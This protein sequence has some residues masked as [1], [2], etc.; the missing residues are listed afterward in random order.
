MR[1]AL[2][3]LLALAAAP[4]FAAPAVP[5]TATPKGHYHELDK[6]PDWGG[7]WVLQP[8]P[9][10]APPEAK[11]EYLAKF[12]AMKKAAAANNGEFPRTASYCSPLGITYLMSLGQYPMEYLFTPGRVTILLEAY[13]QTRKV[14]TDGRGHP[15]EWEPTLFGHSIGHW[16]GDTL[17]VETVG[18]KDAAPI[19]TGLSHSDKEVVRERIHLDPANPDILVDEMVVTDPEALAKPWVNTLRFQR[20][21]EWD[22][23]EYSCAEN[24]LNPINEKGTAIFDAPAR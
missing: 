2:A 8:G 13:M 9:P 6:L 15:E 12:E 18:I 10:A 22:L 7:V 23:I 4:A 24:D 21:R 14:F 11:G 20:H 1:L 16:E 3:A 5:P 17:V 19:V